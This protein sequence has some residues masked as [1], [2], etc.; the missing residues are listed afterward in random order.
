MKLICFRVGSTIVE[1]EIVSNKTEDSDLKQVELVSQLLGQQN[2][3]YDGTN[4][5]TSQIAITDTNGKTVG[6]FALIE[7]NYFSQTPWYLYILK[8]I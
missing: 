6:K 8:N 3:E 5:T 4:L 7:D 1:H 2:I